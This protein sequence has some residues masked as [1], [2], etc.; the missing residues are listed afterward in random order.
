[1]PITLRTGEVQFT[2]ATITQGAS[3]ATLSRLIIILDLI[4]ILLN[5][6]RLEIPRLKS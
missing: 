3:N 2:K 4:A 5:T 6:K 1:M